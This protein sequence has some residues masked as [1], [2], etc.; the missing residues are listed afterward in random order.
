MP[1]VGY[2]LLF[3][4]IPALG[5]LAVLLRRMRAGGGSPLLAIAAFSAGFAAAFPAWFVEKT[6][7]P[8][9]K[10]YTGIAGDALRAFCVAGLVEEGIKTA[11]LLALSASRLF[12]RVSDGPALAVAVGLGF[13]FSENIFFSLENPLTLVLRNLTSVPLHVLA[14]IVP[15]WC[16]G[17]SRFAYKPFIP[18]G[19]CAAVLLHGSY[20]FFLLRG[21]VYGI[22]SFSLLG[23][24]LVLAVFLFRSARKLDEK[25]G[26]L[27][28]RYSGAE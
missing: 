11:L 16:L 25:E 2:A 5:V 19:F 14:L 3:S 9:T 1:L 10:W 17:M 13:A 22:V 20:N 7:L 26:R 6:V 23:L 28:R 8:Y 18:L 27:F 12:R 21:G 24:T 4:G 15:G